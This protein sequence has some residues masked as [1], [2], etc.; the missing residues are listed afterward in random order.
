MAEWRI[1]LMDIYIMVNLR[2]VFFSNS[3]WYNKKI[4]IPLYP[5]IDKSFD[6]KVNKL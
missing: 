3:F 5:Y 6:F 1:Y 2:A 4:V